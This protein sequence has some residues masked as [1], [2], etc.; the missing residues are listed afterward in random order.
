MVHFE[1]DDE[2]PG[3]RDEILSG[4]GCAHSSQKADAAPNDVPRYLESVR[5]PPHFFP[6]RMRRERTIRVEKRHHN[7]H[8]RPQRQQLRHPRRELRRNLVHAGLRVRPPRVVL[9]EVNAHPER[10]DHLATTRD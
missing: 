3:L 8:A 1:E 7:P 5:C 6:H 9:R 10:D 4:I 2:L